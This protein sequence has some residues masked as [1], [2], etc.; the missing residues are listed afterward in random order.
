MNGVR[1]SYLNI[2]KVIIGLITKGKLVI[3]LRQVLMGTPIQG[4][5][6]TGGWA[7]KP[8][9]AVWMAAGGSLLW[10]SGGKNI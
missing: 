9:W 10:R 2:N 7:G 8:S 4:M 1:L 3:V 6:Q 5:F